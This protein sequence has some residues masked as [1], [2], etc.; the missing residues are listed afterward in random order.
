M[1]WVEYSGLSR[2]VQCNINVLKLKEE[3]GRGSE[4]DVTIEERHRDGAVL[5]RMMESRK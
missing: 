5:A 2:W 4:G 3:V 1:R